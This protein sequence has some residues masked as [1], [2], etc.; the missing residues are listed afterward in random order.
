MDLSAGISN[1]EGTDGRSLAAANSTTLG[2]WLRPSNVAFFIAALAGITLAGCQVTSRC[3]HGLNVC[4]LVGAILALGLGVYDRTVHTPDRQTWTSLGESL[5]ALYTSRISDPFVQVLQ[6][7]L[8]DNPLVLHLGVC[9]P[10]LYRFVK[11]R[12][13]ASGD[14]DDL[15]T[16][17][18]PK[19]PI[20][21]SAGILLDV[22]TGLPT[23]LPATIVLLITY[24]PAHWP[25]HAKAVVMVL[26]ML[27]GGFVNVAAG[28]SL[29][30]ISFVTLRG[31]GSLFSILPYTIGI[32]RTAREADAACLVFFYAAQAPP[33]IVHARLLGPSFNV[34]IFVVTWLSHGF[35]LRSDFNCTG[36]VVASVLL[37]PAP[38]G[39]LV[40]STVWVSSFTYFC[41]V[42][43]PPTDRHLP[44]GCA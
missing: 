36:W 20:P 40:I 25:E 26:S 12:D 3:A 17:L 9:A 43:T 5:R 33:W 35:P 10:L 1:R 42:S 22:V 7:S 6:L 44:S 21:V 13:V 27:L 31:L 18:H 39:L 38:L 16:W 32:C 23:T 8:H 30:L 15:V 4:G 19:H 41:I 14:E 11:S 2:V 37:S 29:A 28:F 34:V 24:M